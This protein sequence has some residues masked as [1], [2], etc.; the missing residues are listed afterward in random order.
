MLQIGVVRDCQST[1][2][3]HAV[4]HAAVRHASKAQGLSAEP[5]WVGT[6]EVARGGGNIL[7]GYGGL[8][9]APGSPNQSQHGA[10]LTLV[11]KII[12]PVTAVD[13]DSVIARPKAQGR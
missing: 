2:E 8:S 3:P 7:E 13:L 11:R 1:Y 12:G 9:I 10:L 4:R 6:E 5:I